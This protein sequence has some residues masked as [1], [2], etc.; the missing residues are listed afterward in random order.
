MRL[1]HISAASYFPCGSKLRGTVKKKKFLH[2]QNSYVTQESWN[3][4]LEWVCLFEFSVCR[5]RQASTA[6]HSHASLLCD[7]YADSGTLGLSL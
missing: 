5:K 1:P 6:I 2:T 3:V 4:F 7:R